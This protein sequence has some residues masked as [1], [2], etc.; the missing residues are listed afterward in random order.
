VLVLTAWLGAYGLWDPDEGRH[1]AIARELYA[2][3]T[4]RGWII[5]SH[6]FADYHDK[7]IL[8]YWLTSLAYRAVGTSEIGARLVSAL[9][10]LATL[11]AMFAWTATVAN[12]RIA[13]RAVLVLVTSVGFVCLGR[14]GSLD[15]LLT[16][17]VTLGLVAVERYTADP[18]RRIFLVVA[19][20]AGGLGMLTKGLVAPLFIVGVPVLHAY[21]TGRRLPP[22]RA[23]ILGLTAF[24]L[25]AAPWYVAADLFDPGYL[26][27]FFLQHHLGR[28][29]SSGVAFHGAPWWYYAPALGL[30]LFPWSALLPAALLATAPRRDPA[31]RYCLCWAALIVGF[32]S[33]SHGKLATYILPALPP[34]AIVV[35]HAIDGLE[36]ATAATRRLAG[37]GLVVVMIVLI[38]AGPAAMHIDHVP[39]D[40]LVT[41]SADYLMVFPV[42]A[43]MLLA[44]W[45][46]RGVVAATNAL[47]ACTVAIVLVF[48]A[49]AAPLVSRVTS[50]QP[51]A[52]IIAAHAE[53]PIVS[54][55]VTPASLM[56]YIGRPVVRLNRPR[57]LRQLLEEQPFTWIVTSPRH[58]EEIARATPVY[59]WVTGGRHVL[60]ATAPSGAVALADTDP[61]GP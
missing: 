20:V 48:Y 53:A 45:R 24:L 23:W 60:Y 22:A 31:L 26:R 9:S 47:A 13:S 10:A 35:A 52:G 50:E 15:M 21:V 8:Y 33:C 12:T 3:T 44:A 32:F 25:V 57:A 14:Y 18:R 58:V 40:R 5:P 42:A 38:V 17:W 19:G 59:P 56:F 7:P 54:Y 6:N 4:W 30:V 2:A 46:W 36:T 51:L 16:C 1:A 34:L 61:A 37:A 27:E 39:W 55:G 28:F 49:H 41:A 29:T 11:G 43:A